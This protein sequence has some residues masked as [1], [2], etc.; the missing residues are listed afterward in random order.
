MR[1]ILVATISIILCFC[2]AGCFEENK[3]CITED[4]LV[5]YA[6]ES[7]DVDDN[8]YNESHSNSLFYEAYMF[9]SAHS[10]RFILYE[11]PG[12]KEDG[13]NVLDSGAV[14]CDQYG[15]DLKKYNNDRKIVAMF[16]EG[17]QCKKVILE[18]RA[19]SKTLAS[20]DV[21]APQIIVLDLD[22]WDNGDIEQVDYISFVKDDNTIIREER[23]L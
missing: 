2:L 13:Y 21:K 15:I 6:K 18:C 19:N 8:Y 11:R 10:S 9:S 14:I 20:F 17:S 3:E 16:N 4:N 22:A 5:S 23:V 12:A 7:L 1:K